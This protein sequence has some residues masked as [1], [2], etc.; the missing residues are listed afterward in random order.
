MD[1]W[2]IDNALT[3]GSLAAVLAFLWTIQRDMRHLSERTARLEG[4]MQGIATALRTATGSIGE[5][6]GWPRLTCRPS[7]S[8]TGTAIRIAP[9][10]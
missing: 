6:A 9:Q 10:R 1:Q 3:V 8:G 2:I 7:A 4:L 5:S